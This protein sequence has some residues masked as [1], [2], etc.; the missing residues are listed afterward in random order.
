MQNLND[1]VDAPGFDLRSAVDI[2]EAGDIV[3]YG[4]TSDGKLHAFLARPL[5]REPMEPSPI[6]RIPSSVPLRLR[7][8][9]SADSLSLSWEDLGPGQNYN[10]YRGELGDWYSHQHVDRCRQ[11][12]SNTS[13]LEEEGSQYFL[14]SG[15]V[16][17]AGMV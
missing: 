10:V 12:T 2:N 3:G 1:L 16:C 6:D 9:R 11:E 7:R 5:G 4:V 8:D 14:V 15:T 17:G 13:L